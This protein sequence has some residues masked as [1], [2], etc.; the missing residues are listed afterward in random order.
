[1]AIKKTNRLGRG[2]SALLGA[3]VPASIPTP[4]K[5][6]A[7]EAQREKQQTGPEVREIDIGQLKAGKSAV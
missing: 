2:L 4:A 7:A 3:E 1:M 6:S 5:V